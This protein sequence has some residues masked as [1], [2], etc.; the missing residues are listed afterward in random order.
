LLGRRNSFFSR[1]AKVNPLIEPL[2]GMR[3]GPG[4]ARPGRRCARSRNSSAAASNRCKIGIAWFQFVRFGI[5]VRSPQLASNAPSRPGARHLAWRVAVANDDIAIGEGVWIGISHRG[6]AGRCLLSGV[7]QT[8]HF[9][10]VRT[11]FDPH[12]KSARPK[13]KTDVCGF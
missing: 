12:R 2:K 11:V 3:P 4:Y 6:G 5:A 7:T 1:L 9:N 8:S 13:F 10:G